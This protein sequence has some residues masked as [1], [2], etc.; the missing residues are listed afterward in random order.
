ME[1]PR[2]YIDCD[3]YSG[4]HA[5]RTSGDAAL[6][7]SESDRVAGKGCD[8][9]SFKRSTPLSEQRPS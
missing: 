3:Q 9:S 7:L 5:I 8:S 1:G 6:K 4:N 2:E